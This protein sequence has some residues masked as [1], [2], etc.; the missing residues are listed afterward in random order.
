[1]ACERVKLAVETAAASARVAA[2][3]R[4]RFAQQEQQLHVRME[5]ECTDASQWP[6][7]GSDIPASASDVEAGG[8]E[9]AAADID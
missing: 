2:V 8:E 1:M 4:Q 3:T 7:S 6:H 9:S 5:T